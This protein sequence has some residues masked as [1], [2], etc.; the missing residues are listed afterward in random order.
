MFWPTD[1]NRFHSLDAPMVIISCFFIAFYVFS[2]RRYVKWMTL[3]ILGLYVLLSLRDMAESIP[4]MN[5]L[6]KRQSYAMELASQIAQKDDIIC[7]N[8]LNAPWVLTGNPVAR[9]PKGRAKEFMQWKEC[10]YIFLFNGE[11][12]RI[13]RLKN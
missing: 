1:V 10:A 4:F 13:K 12:W 3:S 8:H 11:E 9:I 5:S 7:T 2:D 6:K